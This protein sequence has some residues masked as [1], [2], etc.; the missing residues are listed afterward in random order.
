[1]CLEVFSWFENVIYDNY[2]KLLIKIVFDLVFFGFYSECKICAFYVYF[3][4]LKMTRDIN[5]NNK[6]SQTL[7]YSFGNLIDNNS[8]VLF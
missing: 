8:C 3:H 2:I 4:S 1:M 6:I 7:Y 5:F